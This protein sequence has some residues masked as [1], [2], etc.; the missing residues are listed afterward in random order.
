M[1]SKKPGRSGNADTTPMLPE[2]GDRAHKKK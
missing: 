2:F 1:C